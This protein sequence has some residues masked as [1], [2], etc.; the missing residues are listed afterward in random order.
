MEEIHTNSC[1]TYKVPMVSGRC[2]VMIFIMLCTQVRTYQKL[3]TNPHL[4]Q[5]GYLKNMQT[6]NHFAIFLH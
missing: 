3:T 6:K 5:H 2:T 4:N 1:R